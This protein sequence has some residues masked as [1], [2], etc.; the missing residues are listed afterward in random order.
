MERFI[1]VPLV[2][3][4]TLVSRSDDLAIS[5]REFVNC[6]ENPRSCTKSEFAN[7]LRKTKDRLALLEQEIEICK[8]A[9]VFFFFFNFLT[10]FFSLTNIAWT[11]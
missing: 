5:A 6:A 1:Q 3:Y 11:T 10:F 8:F 7:V 9:A 4:S 2:H